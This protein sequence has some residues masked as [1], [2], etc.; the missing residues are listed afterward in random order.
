[1]G[2]VGSAVA[3]GCVVVFLRWRQ[4]LESDFLC[5][6]QASNDERARRVD[7]LEL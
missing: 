6:D 5:T 7:Q 1:M 2:V 4:K 3:R